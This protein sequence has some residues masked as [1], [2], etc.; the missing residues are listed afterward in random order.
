MQKTLQEPSPIHMAE[1][2]EEPAIV[3]GLSQ[4]VCEK[5]ILG[6]SLGTFA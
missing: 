4:D 5:A 6:T 2:P 1:L 3:A